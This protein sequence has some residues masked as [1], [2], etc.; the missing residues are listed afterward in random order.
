MYPI[1][2]RAGSYSGR[3]NFPIGGWGEIYCLWLG[4]NARPSGL[5][6]MGP[7]ASL[8]PP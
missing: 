2:V 5:F 8:R 1:V 7:N 3:E 6:K 4:A